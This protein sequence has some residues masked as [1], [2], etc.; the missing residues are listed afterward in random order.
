MCHRS[1]APGWALGQRWADVQRA[2][3]GR[4]AIRIPHSPFLTRR[5]RYMISMKNLVFVIVPTV[6]GYSLVS[7][8]HSAHDGKI[9]ALGHLIMALAALL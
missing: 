4:E 9:E 5:Y 6:V 8:G 3:A 2:S 1:C 7:V